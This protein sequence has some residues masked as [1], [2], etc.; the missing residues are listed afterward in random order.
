M[1]NNLCDPLKTENSSYRKQRTNPQVNLEGI[2][3]YKQLHKRAVNRIIYEWK[4]SHE[5][6]LPSY[7]MMKISEI[8][9]FS[10]VSKNSKIQWKLIILNFYKRSAA[11]VFS[12]FIQRHLKN[13]M[14][15]DL[16]YPNKFNNFSLSSHSL[17][18]HRKPLTEQQPKHSVRIRTQHTQKILS[19]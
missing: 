10:I 5:N 8:L 9:S 15:D 11:K 14:P 12:C 17:F 4:K 16:T 13:L 2:S 6:V 7:R 18:H 3:K 1:L 19:V